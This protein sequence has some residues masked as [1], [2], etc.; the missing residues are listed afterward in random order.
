MSTTEQ[1]SGGLLAN[2]KEIMRRIKVHNVVVSAAGIAFYGLLALVPTLI[3]LVSV[4]AIVADPAEIESQVTSAAESLSEDTRAFVVAQLEGIVG[5]VE[6]EDG[7]GGSAFGRWAGLIFGIA[8]ALFSASGA[9][10][11][12]MST[13]TLAY[14]A[15]ETRPGWKVRGLAYLFT[16]GAIFGIALMIFSIGVIP[17]LLDVVELGSVAESAISIL[18]LPA[19]GLLFAGALTILYRFTPDRPQRTPWWNPGAIVG[20]FLFIFFAIAFSVYSSNVGALPASYGLL[21]TIAAL[22]IFLQLTALA[23]II[24]AEVNG[25]VEARAAAASQNVTS[26]AAAGT[27]MTGTTMTGTASQSG[28]GTRSLVSSGAAGPSSTGTSE[29][30][31]TLSFG[32]ALAGLLALFA[33][34]RGASGD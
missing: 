1:K 5:D 22:M 34:G 4:Y 25:A 18:I 11:K 27:T 23:V 3:A 12:L 20:T 14:E 10:Q 28:S 7:S 26:L 16:A 19:L 13:V 29:P 24:G 17:A 8:V 2:I 30:A 32:K 31:P 6:S 21:G 9:V 15:T 33:L